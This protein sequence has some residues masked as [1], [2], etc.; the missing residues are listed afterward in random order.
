MTSL[1]ESQLKAKL[2]AGFKGR[3]LQGTLRRE[4]ATAL[5]DKGDPSSPTITTY[6]F[7]GIRESFSAYYKANSGIPETDVGILILQGS[8]NPATTITDA[9]QGNFV[10]MSTPWN[11]WYK[12]RR[13]LE[14]DPAGASARLQCFECETPT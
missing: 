10:F 11:K 7:E 3:L 13:V 8:L 4:V 5:D 12:I 1:L 14:I 2:A 6:A 9:D